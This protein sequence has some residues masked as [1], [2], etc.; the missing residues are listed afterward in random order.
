M[1]KFF[2]GVLW[3]LIT[4]AS[5]VLSICVDFAFIIMSIPLLAFS[6]V[7]LFITIADAWEW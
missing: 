6:I 5:I 1:T 7:R 4:G 3:G 2:V